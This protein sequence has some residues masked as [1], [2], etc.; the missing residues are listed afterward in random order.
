MPELS[1]LRQD[2]ATP[3]LMK[4]YEGELGKVGA[5]ED[6]RT[7]H[8]SHRIP[9]GPTTAASTSLRQTAEA[10]PRTRPRRADYLNQC[11][12]S[13]L[14][15]PHHCR[16]RSLD[17]NRRHPQVPHADVQLQRRSP[18]EGKR[19]QG[20]AIVRSPRIKGFPRSCTVDWI[21]AR[22]VRQQSSDAS[23]KVNDSRS[24]RHH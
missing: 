13:D 4:N 15:H 21:H 16:H 24:H 9:L 11:H 7:D 22:G 23:K 10:I 18:L 1:H 6:H 17:A 5:M 12:V 20:T 2:N 14:A 8:P 3:T 19:H